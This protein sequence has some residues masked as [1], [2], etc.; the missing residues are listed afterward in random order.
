MG[1][2]NRTFQIHLAGLIEILAKNLY[3]EPDVFLREMLQ[4]A[5]DSIISRRERP[6]SAAPDGR[7]RITCNQ[8]DATISIDDNGSGLTRE[9]IIKYLATIGRSGT[10]D[11]RLDLEQRGRTVELIGQFGIGL[12]SAFIVAWRV[13]II[14]NS[15]SG[16]AFLW[17]CDGGH[18][19]LIEEGH[20]E[21][22]GTTVILH[23]REQYK[24]YLQEE[25]I[26]RI[27][28][29]YADF[30]GIPIYLGSEQQPCNAI[31][32]P[33]DLPHE[34]EAMRTAALTEFWVKRFTTERPLHV[35]GVDEPITWHDSA[36]G[37][38]RVGRVRG[39][40]GITD[41][42]IPDVNVR[43][44][45]DLYI[46]RMFINA[47]NRDVLPEWAK[48]IQ[49]VVECNELTP[50]AARDNAIRNAALGAVES[51][52]GKRITA[53]LEGLSRVDR[54]R[55]V[56]IMRWHRYHTLA[57]AAQVKHEDFFVAIADLVPLNCGNDLLTIPE[58]LAIA[59]QLPDDKPV[60]YYLTEPHSS[61]Q[62]EF[63]ADA[64]GIRVFDCSSIFA[65]VFLERYVEK[66]PERAKL[67][68]FDIADAE[69]VFTSVQ[70]TERTPFLRV[71]GAYRA[72]FPDTSFVPQISR[73]RPRDIPALLAMAKGSEALTEIDDLVNDPTVPPRYK[74][75]LER[76]ARSSPVPMTLHLNADNP[77]IQRLAARP[78]VH[79]AVSRSVLTSLHYNALLL[80]GSST[81]AGEAIQRIFNQQNRAIEQMLDLA[82]DRSELLAKLAARE[83]ELAATRD[84]DGGLTSYV[85]CFVAMPYTDQRAKR[86]YDALKRVLEDV[87]YCW[88]VSRADD[89]VELPGLWDN[90]RSKLTRSHCFIAIITDENPNVMIEVGRMEALGSPLLL[91]QQ[92]EHG[93]LP[94][95]L[96][97]RLYEVIPDGDPL[98]LRQRVQGVLDRQKT[99]CARQ[100]EAFLSETLLSAQGLGEEVARLLSRAYTT[101]R[102]LTEADPGTDAVQLGLAAELLT[103]A[104]AI[105]RAAL[106][107]AESR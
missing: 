83:V 34:R 99:F 25:E 106:A 97:G 87:P 59:P 65:Q 102:R 92:D 88:Q 79:D 47:S 48:F 46:Q 22:V 63:L 62:Y 40:L 32:A 80:H 94:T 82:D 16:P 19:Y 104:Q 73:F 55:F 78:D 77:A 27:V 58:Y 24:H 6:E 42:H 21:D 39:V 36:T 85:S 53:E 84:E 2:E 93:R 20:R 29:R 60:I 67:A 1:T 66:W 64:R 86:L 91:L 41:R 96:A 10:N 28:R 90:L 14:T 100:G 95:D 13:D 38:T 18:E 15:G 9:E 43:G 7:I 107:R 33:W 5:H 57:M 81:L 8:A 74:E 69:G 89:S 70:G 103:A 75:V 11:L 37:K 3:S 17:R 12:L 26:R 50:N 30:I 51:A 105:A 23:L 45:V 52:L 35:F 31:V 71:E 68:R 56:Q 54:A 98:A 61:R 4:N 49:G 44:T 101:C 76:F 72:L